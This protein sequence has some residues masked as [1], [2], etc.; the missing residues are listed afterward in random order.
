MRTFHAFD[1]IETEDED[2]LQCQICKK[3]FS[4]ATNLHGHVCMGAVGRRDLVHYGLYFAFEK[5]DQHEIDILNMRM[6][7]DENVDAFSGIPATTG[8]EMSFSAK[9]ACS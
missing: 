4:H 1:N 2:A 7:A 8:T 5:I 3:C 6:F 9:W